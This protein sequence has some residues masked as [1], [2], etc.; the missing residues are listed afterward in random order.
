MKYKSLKR[1]FHDPAIDEKAEY[2]KRISQENTKI[3]DFKIH[4]DPAFFTI[5]SEVF[6]L[7]FRIQQ[8]NAELS[9]LSQQIPSLRTMLNR[10][11]LKEIE[12]S[13]EIEGVHSSRKELLA[14]QKGLKENKHGRFAGQLRQY[15]NLLGSIPQ[16]PRSSREIRNL[17]DLL[18]IEDIRAEEP[19]SLP[20]GQI[21]R[22]DSV[23]VISSKGPVHTGVSPETEIIRIL[24]ETLDQ[25][26]KE[27]SLI[28]ASILHFVFGYV[29]PFYDGN[30]RLS[31][32]LSTVILAQDFEMAGI[33]QLSLILREN[34]SK[35]YKAFELCESQMNRAD[36]TPFLISF[37]ELILL[38]FESGFELL[39]G[40]FHDYQKGIEKL[41]S[42]NLSKNSYEFM[43]LMLINLLFGYQSLSVY[44]IAEE[45]NISIS[46]A[47][48]LVRKCREFLFED[49]EGKS[50]QY[51]LHRNFLSTEP[52]SE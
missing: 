32:Y 52:Q 39:S 42:L 31:R 45:M 30:G 36:L 48:S 17:Y 6:D 21:F 38:S 2:T 35:Y 8:K 10:C 51:T 15:Q 22:A 12:M 5:S 34:R 4:G 14:A 49:K 20:D 40:S 18:L 41:K 33:L 44:E 1:C 3:L 16:M 9:R 29:H 11:L 26:S 25:L 47:R 46:T 13:N 7:C 24:N 37:L 19:E 50:K 23:S 28:S 27:K 43:K